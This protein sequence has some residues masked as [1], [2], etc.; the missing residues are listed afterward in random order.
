VLIVPGSHG[1]LSHTVSFHSV[2][3]VQAAPR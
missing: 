1:G 3:D 2:T